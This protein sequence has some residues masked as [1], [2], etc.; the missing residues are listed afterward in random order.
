MEKLLHEPDS[1][2]VP[3]AELVR[4]HLS[5]V[6]ASPHFRTSKRSAAF[7]SFVVD[8]T[9]DGHELEIKERTIGVAVFGRA[10]DYETPADPIVRVKANE[11]RKRLA[12]Y[13]GE[14]GAEEA[15]RIDLPAGAY[16]PAFHWRDSRTGRRG[17]AQ[18]TTRQPNRFPTGLVLGAGCAVLLLAA[19]LFYRSKTIPP[20][21][22]LDEFWAPVVR[23]SEP[24]LLCVGVSDTWS[25]SR[26][27]REELER[28]PANGSEPR[29][30]SVLPGE[31][32]HLVN[33]HV[34]T[35]NFESVLALSLLLAGKGAKP[36]LRLGAAMSLEDIGAHPV[37]SI[38]AFNNPW[39]IRGN[40]ELR[41][42]FEG[43]GPDESAPLSIKDRLHPE[44]RWVLSERYPW[45]KQTVDYAIISRLFDPNSGNVF[46]TLGG[47]NSFGSQ[48][49]G[50]FVTEPRYWKD[51]AQHA[52]AGWQKKNLQ[53]VLETTVVGTTPSPPRVLA[54][55]FW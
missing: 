35:A 16:I 42:S 52:P 20:P 1:A 46:I 28:L 15:V 11:V 39:T 21:S 51:I 26:R 53:I 27:L 3:P 37:I 18:P 32:P 38:G 54:V 36:Q 6:L 4:E 43:D 30:V 41:F 5:R 24:P 14:S 45:K 19:G 13:Y 40:E 29:Q 25:V 48:V 49:A 55:H 17:V 12:Q 33:F 22:A 31:L 44:N 7:L 8:Q 50:E 2:S 34:S 47:I 10:P 23:S 9:L